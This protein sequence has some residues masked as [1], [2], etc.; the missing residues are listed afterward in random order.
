MLALVPAP[1]VPVMGAAETRAITPAVRTRLRDTITE[2]PKGDRPNY[3]AA[4]VVHDHLARWAKRGGQVDESV[5]QIAA[6]TLVPDRMVRRSLDAIEAA[7]LALR[8]TRG[9]G[10]PVKGGPRHGALRLLA[11]DW[12]GDGHIAT[13]DE[14]DDHHEREKVAAEIRDR[15]ADIITGRSPAPDDWIHPDELGPSGRSEIDSENCGHLDG[16]SCDKNC[17]RESENCDREGSELCP[18]GRSAPCI[19]QLESP[20]PSAE[21]DDNRADEK[22]L[23]AERIAK[24]LAENHTGRN[25]RT[26][27][28]RTPSTKR[29]SDGLNVAGNL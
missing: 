25:K 12:H 17:D 13:R 23:S 27:G 2:L 4:V 22:K 10:R 5:S 21:G 24:I 6:A 11:L 29:T 19:T 26:A 18:S 16:Q 3:Y 1:E 15:D 7:G 20:T 8:L 14:A 9:G 28:T